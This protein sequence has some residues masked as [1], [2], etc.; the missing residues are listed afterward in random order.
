MRC[1]CIG[2]IYADVPA[3]SNAMQS[4]SCKDAMRKHY[5]KDVFFRDQS[6]LFSVVFLLFGI[7]SLLHTV[8][9]V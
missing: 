7:S 1:K 5:I 8:I 9:S 6:K 3:L 2:S 4:Y